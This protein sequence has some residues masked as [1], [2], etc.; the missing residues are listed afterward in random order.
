MTS[1]V[2]SHYR[3]VST[4]RKKIVPNGSIIYA[5]ISSIIR[6]DESSQGGVVISALAIIK[7]YIPIVVVATT[8]RKVLFY[9]VVLLVVEVGFLPSL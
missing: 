3:V 1:R 6:I 7:F 2:V 5:Q 4:V 8:P 9:T